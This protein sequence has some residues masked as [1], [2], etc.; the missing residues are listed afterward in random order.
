MPVCELKCSHSFCYDC[1]KQW[2]EVNYACPVCQVRID[3]AV[4]ISEDG[5]S[6]SIHLST[7][8]PAPTVSFDCLDHRFFAQELKKLQN[9]LKQIE[10]D[11]FKRRGSQGTP[12]EYKVFKLVNTRVQDLF[13]NMQALVRFEPEE[14]LFEVKKIEESTDSLNRGIIPQGWFEPVEE[15]D[16]DDYYSDEDYY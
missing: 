6:Q 16:D 13:S 1:I 3:E 8:V 2:C 14:M 15:Y 7:T 4:L 11:R 9:R 5:S 12:E 10:V